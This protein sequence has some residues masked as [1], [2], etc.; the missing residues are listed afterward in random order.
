M[1]RRG[2]AAFAIRAPTKGITIRV[3][4]RNR[5]WPH[6]SVVIIALQPI[7][8]GTAVCNNSDEQTNN[9]VQYSTTAEFRASNSV[10]PDTLCDR[11][12]ATRREYRVPYS[13]YLASRRRQARIC[14]HDPV[15]EW[16]LAGDRQL[17]GNTPPSIIY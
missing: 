6:S 16:Q 7:I 3:N 11:S 14:V 5:L 8:T 13:L 10:E 15:R 9:L 12:A 17:G 2:E 4:R 1:R